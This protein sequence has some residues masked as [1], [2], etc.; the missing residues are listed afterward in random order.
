MLKAIMLNVA[1][2]RIFLEYPNEHGLAR[3]CQRQQQTSFTD[4]HEYDKIL[5]YTFWN[6]LRITSR[7][8]AAAMEST[9]RLCAVF[10]GNAESHAG[11]MRR[12][13]LVTATP[14]MT[15]LDTSQG[16]CS[17]T[18]LADCTVMS[19]VRLCWCLDAVPA[20]VHDTL[21]V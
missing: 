21:P 11:S 14:F 17:L 12:S 13:P 6:L 2:H 19:S 4:I 7:L 16:R 3:H 1:A 18:Y 5:L 9:L 20:A 15:S 8:A 10:V